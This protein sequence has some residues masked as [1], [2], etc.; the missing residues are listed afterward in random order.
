MKTYTKTILII[1]N[2]TLMIL[3]Q[4]S[5]SGSGSAS[6]SVSSP[7]FVGSSLSILPITN[8]ILGSWESCTKEEIGKK[9]E[10]AKRVCGIKANCSDRASKSCIEEFESR[11]NA[12]TTGN[13]EGVY[14]ASCSD[15]LNSLS[16]PV[17]D[18]PVLPIIESYNCTDNDRK[19]TMD[20]CKQESMVAR[21][22]QTCG[23]KSVC[24][25][26]EPC[27]ASFTST[28]FAC[29][30]PNISYVEY[31]EC[32]FWTIPD[33]VFE[34]YIPHPYEI[35]HTCPNVYENMTKPNTTVGVAAEAKIQ[36][37]DKFLFDASLMIKSMPEVVP[38]TKKGSD[39]VCAFMKN[40]FNKEN[41]YK[42]LKREDA[43]NSTDIVEY[44]EGNC[45][46]PIEC[47][48]KSR[49]AMCT[50]EYKGV[51]GIKKQSKQLE[52]EGYICNDG[53]CFVSSGTV[54][55]ACSDPDIIRVYDNE[56][57]L[58]NTFYQE[59][60]FNPIQYVD[61][62]CED[63]ERLADMCT[64]DYKPVC[65]RKDCEGENCQKT[66]SNECMACKEKEIIRITS[67]CD[68][69]LAAMGGVTT[70]LDT[71]M[72]KPLM[73]TQDNFYTTYTSKTL[74]TSL[75]KSTMAAPAS[76]DKNASTNENAIVLKKASRYNSKQCTTNQSCGSSSVC[77]IQY[78]A[79]GMCPV[80]FEN[81][82]KACNSTNTTY[83]VE[84][85]CSTVSNKRIYSTCSPLQASANCG[86]DN[87]NNRKVCGKYK[88][89]SSM[90]KSDDCHKTYASLCLACNETNIESFY[91]GECSVNFISS[92]ISFILFLLLSL[93]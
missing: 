21:Y 40:C 48:S 27:E 86:N 84:E 87:K 4:T 60:I 34:P 7:G 39:I 36:T 20:E 16:N 59:M 61:R 43:C 31:R 10:V 74:A 93:F 77:A 71:E 62:K 44:F 55:Q 47:S 72:I 81:N 66:Y 67:Y 24:N 26:D 5:V 2:L 37:E 42:E 79:S 70:D 69:E 49:N 9:C 19:R 89:T 45:P 14:Y 83:F 23:I 29:I 64:A 8:P 53:V 78:C 92:A 3:S 28:C 32:N 54:C 50:M 56:C 18:P 41:C 25:S 1:L 80:Q 73:Q 6:S 22:K 57:Y 52:E 12:C 91:E 65:G 13:F 33:Y 11:C 35:R 46:K 38:E 90:C 63:K 76:M 88:E 85:T 58:L 82:C 75:E 17:V 30:E 15:Y 68:F 51:C